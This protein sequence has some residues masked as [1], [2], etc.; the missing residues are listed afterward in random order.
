MEATVFF[1]R[2]LLAGVKFKIG[3]EGCRNCDLRLTLYQFESRSL[4]EEEYRSLFSETFSQ[5]RLKFLVVDSSSQSSM[6]VAPDVIPVNPSPTQTEHRLLD[7]CSV[8][9]PCGCSMVSQSQFTTHNH[10]HMS[11]VATESCCQISQFGS[12]YWELPSHDSQ[13]DSDYSPL[14]NAPLGF[15]S[16]IYANF[17]LLLIGLL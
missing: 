6:A 8:V 2:R 12:H 15:D 11:W 5:K 17:F 10:I 9:S 14:S 3:E 13:M 7:H 4:R 16:E 1:C